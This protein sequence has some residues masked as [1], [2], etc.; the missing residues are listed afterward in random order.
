[1]KTKIFLLFILPLL[2]LFGACKQQAE[3]PRLRK[4]RVVLDWTP[5]TNH[6]GVYAAKEMGWYKELGLDVQIIQ[7]GENTAEKIVASAQ[8]EFGFSYQESVSI[9]RSESLPIKSIAAV[10]QHNSSGFASLK[11]ARI[12][13]PKDFAG[14][15][16]GSSSWPSE[17]DILRQVMHNEGASFESLTVVSG[18]HDFFST[19]GRDADF[20]WIFYG[21]DGVRAEITGVDINF[22]PAREIDPIFDFYTPV[23]ITNDFLANSEPQL[24]KDFLDATARGYELC[25][26]DPQKAAELL[27]KAVPE[28]D[29]ELVY[30]SLEYLSQEYQGDAPRW[31]QQDPLVWKRFADWMYEKRIIRIAIN[32]LEAFTNEFLP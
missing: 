28:L 4:V 7:P 22:M 30:A 21:W 6:A 17:L 11:S 27:L 10:I 29:E 19:I 26:N 9:A 25:K 14:K 1:M 3:E 2:I 16:Y 12:H 20:A 5:N 8:A 13:S 15:R 32:S 24:M 18:I 31:G 23:L